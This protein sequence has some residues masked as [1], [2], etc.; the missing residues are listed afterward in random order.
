MA[1]VGVLQLVLAGPVLAQ[2]DALVEAR[3][4]YNQGRYE[5]ALAAAADIG[6]DSPDWHA[7]LLLVGRAGLERYRQTADAND[8]R[9]A[10]EA[11]RAIDI[12]RIDE[13]DRV[14]LIVGLGQ[15]LY[16]GDAF[17][18]AARLFESAMAGSH[19]LGPV[20]RDQLLD[21]WAT[22]LDRFAQTRPADERGEVY[23]LIV[24]RMDEELLADPTT[25][26]ASYWV[27]VAARSKGDLDLALDLAKAGWV[28]AQ[29]TRDRGAWLRP[30]L[31]RLVLQGIIPERVKRLEATA[32]DPEQATTTMVAEWEAFKRRWTNR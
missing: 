15:A 25:G 10:R 28:R 2:S 12:S 24:R 22:S 16:H 32:P 14:E 9:N 8:L 4:L 18:P 13:R 23:D 5:E 31:D 6:H 7:A 20:A 17:R 27:A 19:V 1:L 11:L 30:D 26:A 29:L 21:W 3:Q